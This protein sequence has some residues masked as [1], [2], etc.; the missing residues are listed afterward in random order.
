MKNKKYIILLFLI[1][2]LLLATQVVSSISISKSGQTT[3][4]TNS[5]EIN[6][7]GYVRDKE[8]NSPVAG[9]EVAAYDSLLFTNKLD[10]DI[11]D[12]NGYYL[13]LIHISE[14]TRPY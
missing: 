4:S 2:G 9:A 7:Y 6:F 14:P 8:A 5:G 12:S 13:S 11:T 1:V 10:S 3:V